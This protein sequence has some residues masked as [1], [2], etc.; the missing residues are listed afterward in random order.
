MKGSALHVLA[1]IASV[2]FQAASGSSPSSASLDSSL[3]PDSY[4]RRM[5]DGTRQGHVRFINGFSVTKEETT[6][7]NPEPAREPLW[8]LLQSSLAA[9]LAL[10]HF[11]ER[12]GYVLPDLPKLLNEGEENACDFHM[13][14]K[15][16]DTQFSPMRAVK[17]LVN[18][19]NEGMTNNASTST[20]TSMDKIQ[21]P[22]FAVYGGFYSSVSMQLSKV[23]GALGIPQISSAS[24]S[25]ALDSDSESRLFARTVATDLAEASAIMQYFKYLNV[26]HV[27]TIFT[28]DPWGTSLSSE[29]QKQAKVHG[30][31]FLSVGYVAGNEEDV[32]AGMKVI[33]NSQ[34]RYIIGIFPREFEDV[35][36]VAVEH[37]IMGPT[38]GRQWQLC[39][40]NAFDKG[41][42]TADK[43]VAQ[44]LHGAHTQSFLSAKHRASKALNQAMREFTQNRTLV[45]EFLAIQ[46]DPWL[47]ENFTFVTDEVADDDFYVWMA[48]DAVITLGLAACQTPGMFTGPELYESI[49]RRSFQGVSGNVFF[50][51]KT[52]TRSTESLP[53]TTFNLMIDSE[54]SNYSEYGYNDTGGVFYFKKQV[55]A[56]VVGGAVVPDPNHPFVYSDNSTNPPSPLPP[57]A[58]EY[59]LV[60]F[61]ALMFGAVLGTTV[62]LSSL[63][64]IVWT[65]TNWRNV[66]VR[67]SQP[68]FLCKLCLG[69]FIM[70]LTIIP[71]SMQGE[72]PSSRLDVACMSIPWLFFVGFVIS[73][74]ALFSKAWRLNHLLAAAQRMRRIQMGIYDVMTPFLAMLMLNLVLLLAWT[75]VAPRSYHRI[76]VDD[77]FDIFG[78]YQETTGLCQSHESDP[79]AYYFAVPLLVV[80]ASSVGFACYQSYKA[81]DLPIEFSESKHLAVSTAFLLEAFLLGCPIVV[82]SRRDPTAYFIVQCLLLFALCMSILLPVF[83]PKYVECRRRLLTNDRSR[84]SIMATMRQ[85]QQS[86]RQ[87]R[88]GGGSTLQTLPVSAGASTQLQ[89]TPSSLG[90]LTFTNSGEIA[91][92]SNTDRPKEE[93]RQMLPTEWGKM[94]IKNRG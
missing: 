60:P 1:L 72:E 79:S 93:G 17:S 66:V 46:A 9:F 68:A 7:T 51:P 27:A 5:P 65:I 69:T 50:D 21:Q 75:F 82:I 35:I 80:N 47:F 36:R 91:L 19:F 44:A 29:L 77:N 16:H 11:N 28:Q 40:V 70:A 64:G 39:G 52:G 37:G 24:T 43:D 90:A 88:L 30:I 63:I 87:T 54:K 12:D 76:P 3:I 62:V 89:G 22:P 20:T 18:A 74:S 23:A 8:I 4:I 56:N 25:T 42:K 61:W 67:A 2:F 26:T 81:S 59:N 94:K 6:S 41:Y 53:F 58:M 86:S 73:S 10:K 48:Y 92:F 33:A 83:I 32:Q 13:T 38:S 34:Y 49:K 78:R 31:E 14:V 71:L 55:T 57:L 45:E 15:I 84:P 85:R